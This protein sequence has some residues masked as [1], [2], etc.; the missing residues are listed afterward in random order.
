MKKLLAFVLTLMLAMTMGITFV[1]CGSDEVA[2]VEETT[3]ATTEE[4]TT[5]AAVD[6]D[7]DQFKKTM[8]DYEDFMDSYCE[9]MEEY[10]SDPNGMMDEYL[11]MNQKYL[12]V[13]EE[14][15]AMDEDEMTD[16][17]LAYYL[18]VMNRINEKLAKVAY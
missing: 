11:E 13:M 5:A 18:E 6:S 10:A 12:T 8:D 2:D 15:E 7:F 14:L 4:V 1:G 9:L 3:E 16:E 17:E